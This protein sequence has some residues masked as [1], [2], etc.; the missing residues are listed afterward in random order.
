MTTRL[1]EQALGLREFG[2]YTNHQKQFY[3][4]FFR[5]IAYTKKAWVTV[6]HNGTG[7]DEGTRQGSLAI[8][9]LHSVFLLDDLWYRPLIAKSPFGALSWIF[10]YQHCKIFIIYCCLEC[11]LKSYLNS[12]S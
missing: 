6:A 2:L 1:L 7:L 8:I 3:A 9:N 4:Y 12:E 11:S 10:H 5:R